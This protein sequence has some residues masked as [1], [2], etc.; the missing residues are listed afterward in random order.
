MRIL[1]LGVDDCG[2]LIA[3]IRLMEKARLIEK[4]AILSN[5]R[6][7][8]EYIIRMFRSQVVEVDR[9]SSILEDKTTWQ[10]QP[11]KKLHPKYRKAHVSI[12]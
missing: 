5:S 7:R 9:R 8:T 3:A 2:E 11:A 6:T 1:V 12:K 4:L 10:R